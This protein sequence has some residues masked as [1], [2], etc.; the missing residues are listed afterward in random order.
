VRARQFAQVRG[1]GTIAERGTRQILLLAQL[2]G[3]LAGNIAE[4]EVSAQF[5]AAASIPALD[6]AL[7]AQRQGRQRRQR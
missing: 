2:A 4:G 5:I 7:D 6:A 3:Y 1:A